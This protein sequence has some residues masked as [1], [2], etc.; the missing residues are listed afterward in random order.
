[1]GYFFVRHTETDWNVEERYSGQS[2]VPTLTGYGAWQACRLGETL[3]KVPIKQ[4]V[5]SDL[6]RARDTALIIA[7]PHRL[8]PL[9]DSRLRE[10]SL[11]SMDGMFKEEAR[12][13]HVEPRFS[14]RNRLF[15]FTDLGGES[16][17]DVLRRH[18]EV[19]DEF[20][21]RVFEG[22]TV[23]VGHGTALRLF[24]TARNINI[25]NLNQGE[26]VQVN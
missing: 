26:F 10:V 9:V 22:D 11:G 18:G 14:T 24:L 21:V 12:E 5:C 3:K 25:R 4:V 15:D 2:D 17:N 6:R 20:R 7:A 19:V 16:Y 13:R 1:V 8:V 23:F